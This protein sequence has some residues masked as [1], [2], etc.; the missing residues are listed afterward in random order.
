MQEVVAQAA[1]DDVVAADPEGPLDRGVAQR[2]GDVDRDHE[3]VGVL[4]A[5]AERDLRRRGETVERLCEA[6]AGELEQA[7][8]REDAVVAGTAGDPVVAG[9]AVEIVVLALAEEDIVELPA[10]DE[11]VAVL[12]VELVC[13]PATDVARSERS[14]VRVQ[15]AERV[16]DEPERPDDDL[17][18]RRVV[19]VDEGQER[20]RLTEER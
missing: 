1:V 2:A 5:G 9:V 20:V 13:A 12:A 19:V 10:V 6:V 18:G 15:P 11:V 14:G 16:V 17:D 8:V 7:V 3:V 4:V